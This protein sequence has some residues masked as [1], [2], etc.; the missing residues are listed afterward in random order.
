MNQTCTGVCLGAEWASGSPPR[1]HN[2]Y[3]ETPKR[4]RKWGGRKIIY[5][6]SDMGTYSHFT[7]WTVWND[8]KVTC[9]CQTSQHSFT[10]IYSHVYNNHSKHSSS[11]LMILPLNRQHV[12]VDRWLDWATP[13]NLFAYCVGKHKRERSAN[14][15]EDEKTHNRSGSDSL[16]STSC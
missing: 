2:N 1:R 5:T 16:L 15:T 3:R 14:N 7:L 13:P 8:P 4:N 10:D 12:R 6:L 9:T 11:L